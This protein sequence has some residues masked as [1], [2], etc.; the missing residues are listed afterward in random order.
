MIFQYPQEVHTRRHGPCGY[1]NY[2]SYKPWLR[3]EFLYRC[4][5]CLWREKWCPSGDAAFSVEH[6]KSQAAAPELSDSYDNLV[7]AC[8]RCNSIRS[9]VE[10]ILDPCRDVFADHLKVDADG[11]ITGRSPKGEHL[12]AICKLNQEDIVQAR[13]NMLELVAVCEADGTKRAEKLLAHVDTSAN[14][15]TCQI[16]KRSGH[17]EGIH[18]PRGLPWKPLRTPKCESAFA[19]S[20][21]L[22]FW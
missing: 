19:I 16:L 5:Y 15:T 7:Y 3:D 18:D 14:P 20:Y 8:C 6:L 22:P 9:D 21:P 2:Q 1:S 13:S 4:V 11:S 12:I 10:M 17:R